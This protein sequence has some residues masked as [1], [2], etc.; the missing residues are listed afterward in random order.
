[1]SVEASLAEF[2]HSAYSNF[3][4]EVLARGY[5]FR[6]F[7]EAKK[8]LAAKERF[9]LLRHDIDFDLSKAAEMARIEAKAGV[10]A[11]YFFMLRTE[12][13]NLFSKTGSLLIREILDRGHYLG[14]HFDCA[15]YPAETSVD[16]F[17]RA[18]Q[19]EASILESWFSTPVQI[20]SYHRPAPNVLMGDPRLSLPYLN[21][22]L[23]LYTKEIRYCSDSRG[24]WK[25][26]TPLESDAFIRGEP[27]HVLVHPIWWCSEKTSALP[28]LN[29][30]L[31]EKH[32][33][34]QGSFKENCT[35]F[36]K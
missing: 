14:L 22:Y 2:T 28:V 30:L 15:S 29:R 26:G 27:L 24:E 3:L 6:S 17:Q 20:V 21:T 10:R 16:Q 33:V 13:Y 5:C 34:F 18:C 8:A 25:H 4:K 32:R 23:P 36:G 7:L 1:M 9:L 11:T 35:V 31:E 12:H 19:T